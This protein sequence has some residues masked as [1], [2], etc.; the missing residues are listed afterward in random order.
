MF[1]RKYI[2]NTYFHY[3][4]HKL[5]ATYLVRHLFEYSVTEIQKKKKKGERR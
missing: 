3:N 5:I 1:S 4:L 2:F